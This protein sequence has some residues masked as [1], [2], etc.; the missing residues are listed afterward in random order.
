MSVT[1]P[2]LAAQ[3]TEDE[4]L[5]QLLAGGWGGYPIARGVLSSVTGHDQDGG[6]YINKGR[7]WSKDSIS[8]LA[9]FSR[10]HHWKASLRAEVQPRVFS[11]P[12]ILTQNQTHK[13]TP[14]LSLIWRRFPKMM[15]EK[16]YTHHLPFRAQVEFIRLV[17]SKKNTVCKLG[18]KSA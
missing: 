17:I 6:H 12:V 4:S 14:Y 16:E 2:L 18:P 9:Q 11:P 5:L 8:A 1:C 10:C 3:P 15:H 7:F 13:D